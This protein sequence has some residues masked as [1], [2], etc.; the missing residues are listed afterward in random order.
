MTIYSPNDFR[1]KSV[2][3]LKD[4]VINKGGF[5][6]FSVQNLQ[7]HLVNKIPFQAT[8][9]DQGVCLDQLKPMAY[10][11]PNASYYDDFN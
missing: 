1:K 3:L 8:G 9:Y 4:A 5:L 10:C 6:Q 11:H 7:Y 2:E